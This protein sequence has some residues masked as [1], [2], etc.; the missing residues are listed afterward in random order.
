MCYATP[1]SSISVHNIAR[2]ETSPCETTRTLFCRSASFT[3][4]DAIASKHLTVSNFLRKFCHFIP[5]SWDN[6]FPCIIGRLLSGNLGDSFKILVI[7]LQQRGISAVGFNLLGIYLACA[8]LSALPGLIFQ[9]P[10]YI[11]FIWRR[12][13]D[14]DPK[15]GCTSTA[16]Q[17]LCCTH[18]RSL[19]RPSKLIILFQRPVWDGL[20]ERHPASS[21]VIRRGFPV[22]TDGIEKVSD[23]IQVG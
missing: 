9:P 10:Q 2:K 21:T 17:C 23:S 19:W 18:I 11:S 16:S 8:G 6:K 12:W 5:G 14:G 4:F 22:V 13:E 7:F 3:R 20:C 15:S 1:Y